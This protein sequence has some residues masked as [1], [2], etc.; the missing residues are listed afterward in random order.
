MRV[1]VV[2]DDRYFNKLLSDHLILC[3]HEVESCLDG[4]S[5]LDLLEASF[6]KN[7]A[8]DLMIIDM[9][10]PKIMG[11]EL[12]T[13]IGEN[14]RF[15]QMKKIGISGVY[16]E[17]SEIDQ[18]CTLHG[19]TAY[20]VKPFDLEDFV[21]SLASSPSSEASSNTE[22]VVK[23]EGLSQGQISQTP[24]EKLF[25]DA[26]N[27]AFTG[28]LVLSHEERRRRIYFLNGHPV[29]A[30]SSIM[31]ESLGESLVQTGKITAEQRQ[32]ASQ[33]M[34]ENKSFLGETLVGLEFITND[35][36]FNAL[37]DHSQDLIIRVFLSRQGNFEFE[38]MSSLPSHIPHLE[39][40]PFLLMLRAQRKYIGIEALQSLFDLKNELY[41]KLLDRLF[42]IISLLDLKKEHEDFILGLSSEKPFKEFKSQ[43]QDPSEDNLFRALY[44]FESI[45]VLEW[46][47]EPSSDQ[48]DRQVKA[49]EFMRSAEKD[50]SPPAESSFELQSE[51]E[52]FS[53]YMDALNKDF[54]E[55]L[56]VESSASDTEIDEAYRKMRFQKHPDRYGDKINGQT[57]RIL[58]D[59]LSRLDSAYQTL[60]NTESKE[61]YLA[62]VLK[63]S[64]DSAADSK[65]YLQA[66]DVFRQALN[67]L[68]AE[69]YDKAIELFESAYQTWKHGLEYRLYKVFTQFKQAVSAEAKESVIFD[70]L[71]HLRELAFSQSSS[72]TGFL[73]L[74]HA[75]Q[76]RQ[77]TEAAID[78][79]R[80]C[81]QVNEHQEEA[82]NAL[83]TL[84]GSQHKKGQALRIAS[85]SI[86]PLLRVGAFLLLASGSVFALYHGQDLFIRVDESVITPDV[87]DFQDIMPM[88]SFRLKGKAAKIS[89]KKDWLANSP[90]PVL[91]SKCRQIIDDVAQYGTEQL[92]LIDEED[93]LKAYCNI[94]EIKRF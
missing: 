85:K 57:K 7:Q 5:A 9:L 33:K 17:R 48:R 38:R 78:A 91:K 83:A 10:L 25:F 65:R 75:Y 81:L 70:H 77:D 55:L 60:I 3:D 76:L 62:H 58:D 8:F 18:L 45:G 46:T 12:L 40:N 69:N 73:L 24:I 51:E 90:T 20:W 92:Y 21:N 37:R 79:Y 82:A 84:A 11:A 71:K 2:D 86:W 42:Q 56:D 6:E 30:D 22:P 59:I 15:D 68:E 43:V 88:T 4:E 63:R 31:Q 26:Y 28:R 35:Q 32:Q 36:L 67:E 50:S 72:D 61:E 66:Q 44:L 87:K 19:M 14:S 80:K 1:L 13:K 93:G 49:T 64:T 94:T 47:T 23:S 54:F 16:K 52:I 39:F 89:V 27:R 41:P 53:E 34:V 74:G 29:S